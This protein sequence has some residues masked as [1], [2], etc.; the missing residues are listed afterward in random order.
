[1][2]LVEEGQ[3]LGSKGVLGAGSMGWGGGRSRGGAATT[4]PNLGTYTQC[5][6]V[7]NHTQHKDT[8]TAAALGVEGAVEEE[9]PLQTPTWVHVHTV[10]MLAITHSTRAHAQQQHLGWRAQ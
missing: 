3:W 8:C 1:M 9:L 6:H 5:A 10:R 4:N 7:G 2:L